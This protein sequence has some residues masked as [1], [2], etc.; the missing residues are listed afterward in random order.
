MVSDP[1]ALGPEDRAL[2]ERVARRTV[3]LHLEVPALLALESLRPLSFAASQALLFFEPFAQALLG[4]RDYRRFA[5]LVERRETL[6]ELAT[7]IEG[8]V[9]EVR[10]PRRPAA[11]AG[12]GDTARAPQEPRR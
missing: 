12:A 4:I 2:L 3:D 5:Q 10:P 11:G 7:M 1:M 6:E 9:A 8:R